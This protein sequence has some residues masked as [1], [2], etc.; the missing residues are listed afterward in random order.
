M[1]SHNLTR[2]VR[3]GRRRRARQSH[4]HSHR[5]ARRGANAAQPLFCIE[6]VVLPRI[7]CPG[8]SRWSVMLFCIQAAGL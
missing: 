1:R 6:F 8:Q 3:C 5:V 4:K 2:G 7:G